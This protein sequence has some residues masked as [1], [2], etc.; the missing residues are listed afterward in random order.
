[1]KSPRQNRWLAVLAIVFFFSAGASFPEIIPTP[2]EII[3]FEPGQDYH[4][5]TYEQSL[6]YYQALEKATDMV[7][8]EFIGEFEHGTADDGGYSF[9]VQKH[10]QSRAL[11]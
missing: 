9:F 6:K 1:M 10:G 7:K 5:L 8:L 3:G 4:L 2:K 11:S